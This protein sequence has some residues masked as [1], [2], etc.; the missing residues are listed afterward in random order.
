MLFSPA[1]TAREPGFG[2]GLADYAINYDFLLGIIHVVV[3]SEFIH[4]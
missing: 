2:I 1:G 4:T 3:N